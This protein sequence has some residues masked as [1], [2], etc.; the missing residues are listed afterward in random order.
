M[1]KGN[2]NGRP[3]SLTPRTQTVAFRLSEADRERLDEA[4]ALL[5]TTKTKV[6]V[7]GIETVYLRAKSEARRKQRKEADGEK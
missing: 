2:P 3:P 7:E 5:N 4:A 1:T 6:V